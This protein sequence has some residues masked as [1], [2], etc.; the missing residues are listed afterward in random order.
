MTFIENFIKTDKIKIYVEE[1]PNVFAIIEKQLSQKHY[2][3]VYNIKFYYNDKYQ[4]LKYANDIND[5]K[6]K[7]KENL[8]SMYEQSVHI[9]T[10]ESFCKSI[11][12][13]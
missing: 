9:Q 7:C 12:K 13:Q 6:R 5:A 10:F 8:R 4:G 1:N 3:E 11:N 2:K